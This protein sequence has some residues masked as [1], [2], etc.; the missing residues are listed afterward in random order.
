MILGKQRLRQ[1]LPKTLFSLLFLP[2][3]WWGFLFVAGF[4]LGREVSQTEYRFIERGHRWSDITWRVYIDLNNYKARDGGIW[5]TVIDVTVPLAAFALVLGLI[6]LF[7]I[8]L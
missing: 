4:F 2:A 3:G 7:G 5:D 1:I 6:K 8:G